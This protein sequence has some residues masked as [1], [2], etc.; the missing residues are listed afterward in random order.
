MDASDT[1]RE[2]LIE[3][4]DP[5][6][7]IADLCRD[8]GLSRRAIEKWRDG[9]TSPTIE[10]LERLTAAKK[11]QPWQVLKKGGTDPT[12]NIPTSLLP[13]LLE[14]ATL[15][16]ALKEGELDML[17]RTIRALAKKGENLVAQVSSETKK[18]R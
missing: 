12:I 3:V 2:W 5:H 18:S 10:N 6:G 11:L 1:F 15:L 17:L 4:T 13:S 16:P 7:A 9:E 14:I 8:T